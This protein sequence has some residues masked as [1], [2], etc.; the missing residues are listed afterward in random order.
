MKVHVLNLAFLSVAQIKE[1]KGNYE[2]LFLLTNDLFKGIY[3]V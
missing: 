3:A 2:Y 1:Y